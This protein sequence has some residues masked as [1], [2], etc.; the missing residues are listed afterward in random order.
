MS[1][2]A[3]MTAISASDKSIWLK[4]SAKSN[5]ES[6]RNRALLPVRAARSRR[7]TCPLGHNRELVVESNNLDKRTRRISNTPACWKDGEKI[8]QK[9]RANL[10]QTCQ[11][12]SSLLKPQ[13]CLPTT[14]SLAAIRLTPLTFHIVFN[15]FISKEATYV[16]RPKT[17]LHL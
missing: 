8:G 14:S 6:T 12:L 9:E 16:P 15:R 17:M 1:A 10:L 3:E 11:Q 5:M 4:R 7:K 13:T 2:I